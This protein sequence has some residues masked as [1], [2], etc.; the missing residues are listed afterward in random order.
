MSGLQACA[1]LLELMGHEDSTALNLLGL[2]SAAAETWEGY[3]IELERDR[4]LDPLKHGSS[5]WITRAGGLLSGP[6]PLALRLLAWKNP[7]LRRAAAMCGI[8]GSLL[9]RYG[10]MRAG[11]ASA[12]DWRLPLEI[13]TR[14]PLA[15]KMRTVELR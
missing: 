13:E 5:G 10:W 8:A 2:F 7:R 4:A 6:I 9:T 1:S 15:D 3:S 11:H 14:T 12:R